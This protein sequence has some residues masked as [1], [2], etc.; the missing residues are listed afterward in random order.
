L[1][2]DGG[3]TAYTIRSSINKTSIVDLKFTRAAPGFQVGRNGT[4]YF[5]TDPS[6][7]WGSMTHRFWPRCDVVGSIITK[8]GQ[9]DFKGRGIFIHALQGM[10]PHLAGMMTVPGI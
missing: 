9:I 6:N 10:K 8:D 7:P 2:L 3:G 5:G 4:T 1:D